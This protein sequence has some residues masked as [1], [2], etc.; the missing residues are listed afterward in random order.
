MIVI[1]S[2]ERPDM[3]LSL[4]EE[5]RDEDVIVIDDG[6]TYDHSEHEKLCKYYRLKHKGKKEFWRNWNV[7]LKKCD[8]FEDDFF[9]FLPDDVSDIKL[10]KIKQIAHELRNESYVYSYLNDGRTT[11][12][13]SKIKESRKIA[14]VDSHNV[15]FVDCGF[16]T[17]RKTLDQLRFEIERISPA[18]FD[19]PRISSGIG[20][21]MTKRLA[22]LNIP[23]YRADNSLAFHGNHESKMNAAERKINPLISRTDKIYINIAST[24]DRHEQLKRTVDSLYDQCDRIILSLNGYKKQEGWMFDDKITTILRNNERG[25]SEKFYDVKNQNGFIFTCDD[26]LIYPKDYVQRMIDAE[27]KYGGI[28]A[29]HGSILR[30]PSRNYYMDRRVVYQC[31]NRVQK[32]VVV[33]IPGT[34]AMC[35]NSAN[36]Q[37]NYDL[38]KHKNMSDI[39]AGIFAKEQK[40]KIT[41]IAHEKGEIIQ[42]HVNSDIYHKHV[43]NCATQTRLVNEHFGDKREKSTYHGFK[44]NIYQR[45]QHG[46]KGN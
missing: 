32:D 45:Y 21:Q 1:F 16:F 5:L 14:D 31:L 41:V 37:F 43:S 3:L 17:N 38:V 29:M 23:M 36:F 12:W 19:N 34:G 42:Q 30:I 9:L 40:V 10:D 33:D 26:D 2:Y 44:R 13:G 46:L 20:Q 24:P 25:C 7:A 39:Y 8:Y 4:L 27:K 35:Y 6:S 15:G 11:C 22:K 18:R 28:V